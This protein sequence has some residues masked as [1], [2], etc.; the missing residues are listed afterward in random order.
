MIGLEL[1]GGLEEDQRRDLW[2]SWK[3]VKLVGVRKEDAVDKIQ[4]RWMDQLLKGKDVF[5][6]YY[7]QTFLLLFCL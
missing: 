7:K 1:A 4:W 3:W 2:M 5:L 6:F